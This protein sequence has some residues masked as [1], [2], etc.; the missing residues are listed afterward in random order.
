MTDTELLAALAELR[1]TIASDIKAKKGAGGTVPLASDHPFVLA[2]ARLGWHTAA[3]PTVYTLLKAIEFAH[4]QIT[5]ESFRDGVSETATHMRAAIAADALEP[6]RD[7]DS[8]NN[9]A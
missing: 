6:G 2:A 5:I 8:P 1:T 3:P 9:E 7:A 4:A